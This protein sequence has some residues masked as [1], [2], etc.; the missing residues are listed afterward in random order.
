MNGD[1][2]LNK[3]NFTTALRR[4]IL[5]YLVG[6]RQEMDIRADTSLKLYIYREDLWNKEIMDKNLFDIEIKQICKDE[7]LVGHCWNLYNLLNG[8][9]ILNDILNIND[10]KK[11]RGEHSDISIDII[12]D[13][14]LKEEGNQNGDNNYEDRQNSD[15]EQIDENLDYYSEI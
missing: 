1:K 11:E 4:L 8:D 5:R 13:F 14:N 2:V 10:K 15:E 6:S 12:A 7:I 3:K 9:N